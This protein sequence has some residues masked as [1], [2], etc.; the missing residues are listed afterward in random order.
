MKPMLVETVKVVIGLVLLA[1][2]ATV[3]VVK[4]LRNLKRKK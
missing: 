3:S 4:K 1:A 2:D